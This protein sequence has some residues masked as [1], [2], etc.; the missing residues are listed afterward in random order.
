MVSGRKWEAKVAEIGG[1]N[2]SGL[3]PAD[4]GSVHQNAKSV[5]QQQEALEIGAK[6]SHDEIS[7]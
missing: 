3:G 7:G 5:C 2:K 4:R 1:L 6:T